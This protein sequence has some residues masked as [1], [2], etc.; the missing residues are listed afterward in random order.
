MKI[1]DTIHGFHIDRIRRLE[2]LNGDFYEM[3]HGLTGARLVWLS[4]S[5]EN[6]TFGIAF[7]TQPQ[8]DT[9]VFHILEHSVLCGSDRYPAREPFVELMKS[10]LNTFLNAMTFPDKTFYPFSSRNDQDFLNLMRVY[11]DAVLH[12]MIYKKPEIFYQEGWHYEFAED[13]TPFYKGVVFNEMKGVFASPD[14]LLQNEMNR[15]LFPDTCYRFVSGGDPEHIPDLTWEEFTDV[16]RRLYHPSNAYIFL[17]GHMDIDTVLKLLDEE[18]LSGFG[19]QAAPAPIPWQPAVDGGNAVLTYEL[20]P[21]EELEG[22]IRCARGYVAGTFNDREKLIALKAL[23]DV[24][25]QGN[26]TPLKKKILENGL[27]R[28]VSLSVVDGVLQPWVLLEIRD[29]STEKLDAAENELLETLKALSENG[30]DHERILATLTNMEFQMRQRDYGRMPQ[31]LVFGI[32]ALESWLYGG[33]PAANLVVGDLFDQLREKCA[34]GY[35]EQLLKEVFLENNHTCRVI[36]E[37]S[38]TAEEARRQAEAQRL[39]KARESW[40]E[41]TLQ[42]LIQR[43]KDIEAWQS[44]PDTPEALATIPMLRLDQIPPEPE[45]LPMDVQNHEYIPVLF[46]PMAT[47]GITYLNLYFALDDLTPEELSRAAFLASL[48]GSLQTHGRTYEALQTAMRTHFGSLSFQVEAYGR[49][50]QPG[51]CRTFLCAFASVLDSKSADAMPL[52]LEM[53]TDTVLDDSDKVLA[54][55]RQQITAL[56]QGIIMSGNSFAMQ[57]VAA[58]FTAEGAVSEYTGGITYL[59]WMKALEKDFANAYPLLCAQLKDMVKRLF[60]TA[61]LTISVTGATDHV[62]AAA[63]AICQKHLPAGSFTQPESGSAT[64]P[65]SGS[66]ARP[67]S[68]SAAQS[69]SSSAAQSQDDTTRPAGGGFALKPCREGIIIPADV[70]F[71][72]LGGICDPENNGALLVANRA[73]SLTYLWNVIRVQGGAY[74]A[75]MVRGNSGF[76]GFYSFRDPTAA[77]TLDYFCQTPDFLTDFCAQKAD[78]DPF[79]IGAVAESDP[80]LTPRIRGKT[81]D[82]RYFKGITH[83]DLCRTRRQ[84]LGATADALAEIVPDLKAMT[85]AA[86]VCVIGSKGQIEACGEKLERVVEL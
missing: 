53:L 28:D 65:G 64:Q 23:A 67:E 69:E 77:R 74:G 5:E 42:T 29:T 2:E 6:K 61:R 54:L 3:T 46:H 60:T 38:H 68:N 55:L 31:G 58:G 4:R 17:D 40:S 78:L 13:K 84:I 22:R 10:S 48:L 41:E 24:L 57:R 76:A 73:V 14:T 59:Q 20:S 15:R 35:F 37:P 33:D 18:Y 34:S 85:G 1:H 9:G 26:Q 52:L 32:N 7:Q 16:H 62:P 56:T 25:C 63:A 43:Q 30:L 19:R 82:S 83:G 49:F 11:M 80:L 51:D 8:N 79:I 21:Q 36:L 12:P 66:V 44:T 47:G 75:G 86:G 70:S 72:F 50:G 81:S 71:A 45:A 27:G 39:L